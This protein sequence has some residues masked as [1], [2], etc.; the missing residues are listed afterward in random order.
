MR[1][2]DLS[3]R[4]TRQANIVMPPEFALNALRSELALIAEA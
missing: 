2:K 3:D 1:L 4:R